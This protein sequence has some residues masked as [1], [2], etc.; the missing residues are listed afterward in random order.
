MSSFLLSPTGL[1]RLVAALDGE[2]V[3]P[4]DP[5]WDA[6]RQAW[7]LAVDQRPT[8]VVAAAAVGDV[9]AT[10]DAAREFGLRV[11]P[12]GTGHNAGPARPARRHH[13]AGAPAR[14]RGGTHRSRTPHRPGSRRAGA[15]SAGVT[16][17]AAEAGLAALGRLR[18]RRRGRRLHP[19]WR[20][21]AGWPARRGLAANS[22][23]AL[24]VVTADGLRPAA[25]SAEHDPDLFWALRGGGGSYAVVTAC[26][27]RLYPITRVYAGALF[28]PIETRPRRPAGLARTAAG[29]LPD[30]VTSVGRLLRFPPL[31][32]LPPHLRGREFVVVEA[33]SQETAARTDELL[34]P[35]R[36][37]HP[38]LD[39][40]ADAPV[41]ELGASAMDPDGP[42]P[43][44]GD[45]MLLDEL[46]EATVDAFVD[47]AGPGSGSVLLSAELRHLG[48]AS[49]PGCGPVVRCRGWTQPPPCSASGSRRTRQP[50][51]PSADRSTRCTAASPDG[52]RAQP[53]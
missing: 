42:V 1:D 2:L 18:A 4:T 5:G 14:L 45:G 39:T 40:L 50:T 30:T 32:D 28:W 35:L 12:Q 20:A 36:A 51:W 49:R 25:S 22:V 31:P 17:P 46:A 41:A 23:T 10:L 48:G 24:E 37:L 53:T 3:R 9:V 29:G 8:A 7:H 43:A 44:F 16:A 6:A 11:A 38:E 26:E 27:F 52:P 15:G 47:A 21:G 34:A 33:V 13:P 19:R